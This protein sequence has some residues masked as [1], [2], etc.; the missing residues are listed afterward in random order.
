M[1]SL[2]YYSFGEFSQEF[3]N[4]AFLHWFVITFFCH[5]SFINF[6]LCFICYH[7]QTW[8]LACFS[9]ALWCIIKL[10]VMISVTNVGICNYYKHGVKTVSHRFGVLF[11]LQPKNFELF[12]LIS[13][14]IHL[15]FSRAV[16]NLPGFVQLILLV[17]SFI[18]L[19][20]DRMQVIILV[21]LYFI[22][23]FLLIV[24]IYFTY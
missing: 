5:F 24:F 21:S 12:F 16:F 15:S 22:Y 6:Y 13:F 14:M 4:T 18:S 8:G 17:S 3:V 9:K 23:L 2:F 1:F 19:W 20:S 7:L 10:F 11:S